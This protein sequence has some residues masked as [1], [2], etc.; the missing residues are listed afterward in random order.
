MKTRSSLL[1]L[2][3]FAA[4][5][6]ALGAGPTRKFATDSQKAECATKNYS[7]GLSSGNE[8][9]VQ[10]C[11]HRIAELKLRMPTTNMLVLQEQLNRL[12]VS[13]KSAAV[14]YKA[15]LASCICADP[16]WFIQETNIPADDQA[17]FFMSAARLLE[18]KVLGANS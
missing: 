3:A 7:L 11:I 17:Q 12:S 1:V 18:Q 6:M 13:H 9:L 14:R 5:N 2:A 15:Y 4:V 8:G 10:S 16:A